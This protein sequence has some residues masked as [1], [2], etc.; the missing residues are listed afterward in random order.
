MI[1]KSKLT[2][3]LHAETTQSARSVNNLRRPSQ[4]FLHDK[5]R[6][7][8][9]GPTSLKRGGSWITLNNSVRNLRQAKATTVC[10]GLMPQNYW[11]T[12]DKA[13]TFPNHMRAYSWSEA[14][15][16]AC[17]R[18]PQVLISD[19]SSVNH[20]MRAWDH[21]TKIERYAIEILF[22]K[23]KLKRNM[24]FKR[25]TNTCVLPIMGASAVLRHHIFQYP[26]LE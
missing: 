24:Q 7:E 26:F 21:V 20:Y 6:W 12:R 5:Q 15:R 16:V 2:W 9:H 18:M 10:C 4:G 17:Y 3:N 25:C 1:K 23:R 19:N 14:A 13:T 8:P 11:V 22:Q